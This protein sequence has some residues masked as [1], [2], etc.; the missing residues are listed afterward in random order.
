MTQD[1][2]LLKLIQDLDL[3]INVQLMTFQLINMRFGFLNKINQTK[4]KSLELYLSL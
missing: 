4:L 3:K 2:Y 1:I